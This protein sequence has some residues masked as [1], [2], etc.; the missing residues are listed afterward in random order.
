MSSCLLS[1]TGQAEFRSQMT[2]P[3]PKLFLQIREIEWHL[4]KVN[5]TINNL[6]GIL[7]YSIKILQHSFLQPYNELLCYYTK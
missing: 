1:A 7:T 3:I 2:K 5:N 6:L 4:G